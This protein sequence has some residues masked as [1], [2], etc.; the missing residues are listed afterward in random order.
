MRSPTVRGTALAGALPLTCAHLWRARAEHGKNSQDRAYAREREQE[1][2]RRAPH[3][4][5]EPALTK[6]GDPGSHDH[7]SSIGGNG[8]DVTGNVSGSTP[9]AI[10]AHVATN[11]PGLESFG[12]APIVATRL[13]LFG[14]PASPA[15]D[16]QTEIGCCH[17]C[18][19]VGRWPAAFQVGMRVSSLTRR[20]RS[21]PREQ[22]FA[23]RDWTG[24]NTAFDDWTLFS[25]PSTLFRRPAERGK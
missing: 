18:E 6:K 1:S 7:F 2:N 17:Y 20:I 5:F 25:A 12:P 10:L 24:A 15:V 9:P 8:H 19:T 13:A 23:R 14:A 3:P 4:P 16:C 21:C 11:E 22:A